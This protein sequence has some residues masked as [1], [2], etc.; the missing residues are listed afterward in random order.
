MAWDFLGH[1]RMLGILFKTEK[2]LGIFQ[3][4]LS[5]RIE[6]Y[7]YILRRCYYWA[8]YTD[9][10][11][12]YTI[13]NIHTYRTEAADMGKYSRIVQLSSCM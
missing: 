8:N 6:I 12:Y 3:T 9:M 10:P 13:Y 4:I 7:F 5:N 2:M 11:I 1:N